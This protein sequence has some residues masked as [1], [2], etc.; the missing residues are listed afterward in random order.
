MKPLTKWSPLGE[1]STL[2]R[3]IDDLFK[4]FFEVGGGWMPSLWREK[5]FPALDSFF[6]EGNLVV[7]AELPGIDPKDVDISVVGNQLTIKGER[8]A[9]KDIH[10]EDYVMLE[11]SYGTFI[12]SITLPEGVDLSKIHT[13]YHDGILDLTMPCA[14]AVTP[15]KINIEIEEHKGAAIKKAA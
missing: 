14:E 9:E 4:R 15:K 3:E 13:T 5:V 11:S 2:H 6:K 12:R 1:I 8:K 7:R 10:D